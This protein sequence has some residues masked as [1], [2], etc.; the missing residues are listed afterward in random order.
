MLIKRIGW[1]NW[2]F[3]KADVYMS[4]SELMNRKLQKSR[5]NSV[6]ADRSWAAGSERMCGLCARLRRPE[7]IARR[8][9]N[10]RAWRTWRKPLIEI[11]SLWCA[12]LGSNQ[13]PLPSEGS[14]L[15][16]ELRALQHE[17]AA[18]RMDA[19]PKRDRKDTRFQ[20]YRPPDGLN[21]GTRRLPADP[22][23]AGKRLLNSSPRPSPPSKSCVYN[24][25][26]LI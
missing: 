8:W 14:T 2:K 16:I 19:T 26:W 7:D 21:G 5:D 1:G 17:S 6:D 22:R 9:K 10:K 24:R 18:T 12:R 20:P 25:P 15:S 4:E 3:Q 23:D 11:D 13:Q